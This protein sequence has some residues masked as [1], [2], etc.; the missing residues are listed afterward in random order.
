M[1]ASSLLALD[2]L[3]DGGQSSLDVKAQLAIF[4]EVCALHPARPIV[5]SAML[6]FTHLNLV[7]F[8]MNMSHPDGFSLS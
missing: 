2:F 4:S 1:S 7:P 3:E 8:D 5:K 6:R